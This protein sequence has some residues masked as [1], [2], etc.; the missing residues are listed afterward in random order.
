MK[1]LKLSLVI[2]A[3]ALLTIG[4]GG[5]AYAFH[6]GGVAYCEGCHTMHNSSGG[7]TMY[8][9]PPVGS[10]PSGLVGAANKYLLQGTDQSSTCLMCHAAAATKATGG[11]AVLTA[12]AKAG[13]QA[14]VTY[15][16]GGDFAYTGITYTWHPSYSSTA[17]S[18]SKAERHGHNVI[19][20]DFPQIGLETT[21]SVAPGGTYPKGSLG[22]HS[23]HDPHGKY[24]IL[25]SDLS[26]ATAGAP[27]IGS[28][29]D[30]QTV[31]VAGEAVGV[32]RLLGG[33]G[34]LPVSV[35]S[36]FA[37]STSVNPPVAVAP[38]TYSA[39]EI[40]APST[41]VRVAYGTGMSEWCA[42]CHGSMHKDTYTSGTAGLVHPASSNI[43]LSTTVVANY[44]AYLGSGN[45]GT[46]IY[47][48]L[49]PFEEGA[50]VTRATLATHVAAAPGQD[51]TTSA[52][53]MC[54]TCHRAHASAWDSMTRW[55]AT[56]GPFLTVDNGGYPGTNSASTEGQKGEL[57][58]G[59]TQAEY[60]AAMNGW[61]ATAF[62]NYQRSLCNKCHAK[63]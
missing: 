36:G 51:A 35:A 40:S 18:S 6:D 57:N 29:S 17:T 37:F 9:K 44:N 47:W 34:Y 15:T 28:G 10:V 32:Y 7:A 55:N 27:I 52:N 13:T 42:N 58:M 20:A 14:P 62:S 12:D 53:V 49:V 3:A 61:P 46:G 8:R 23:C 5:L 41:Q 24:R 48:S 50:S 16:P 60:A 45:M 4:L 19:A 31:P 22:C 1:A 11:H 63:D 43:P 33:K 56:G 59:K 39:A 30:W 21:L 54:L 26:V 38:T 25:G 2:M